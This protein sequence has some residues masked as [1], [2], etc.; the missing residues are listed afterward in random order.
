MILN[1]KTY[2]NL[3]DVVH[4]KKNIDASIIHFGLGA[5]FKAHFCSYIQAYNDLEKEIY[6]INA[7]SFKSNSTKIIMNQ[8]DNLYTVHERGPKNSSFQVI[9][10]IKN[11]LFLEEDRLYINDLLISKKTQIITLTIT[12]KGYY[13]SP[14]INGLDINNKDIIHDLKNKKE[15]KSAIGLICYALQTRRELK[16]DGLT[17]MSCDNL[18]SNGKILKKVI[19]DFAELID[20]DLKIWIE[21]KCTFP[22]TMVDRIVPKMTN[23]SYNYIE[24]IIKLKDKAGIVCED[25]S[26]FVI[27]DKFIK[28]KPALNEVGVLYVKDIDT[29]ENMK[30]RILNG[31]HSA[32]AYLGV[33]LKKKT[34]FDT[35]SEDYLELFIKNLLVKE[36]LPSLQ[37]VEGVNLNVYSQKILQRYRN[38]NIVHKTIQICMDGSLKLPQRWLS[39]LKYLLCTNKNYT[40]FALCLAAW[41]KCTSSKNLEGQSIE[42]NDPSALQYL[43]IWEEN[44]SALSIVY[45]YFSLSDIFEDFFKNEKILIEKVANYLDNIDNL[46]QLIK[47]INHENDL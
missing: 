15:A 21:N 34:I 31:T 28:K 36:I 23:E 5:F 35:I 44:E 30:L 7:I 26:Q 13:Y 40:G 24:E 3:T 8:Q 41:I 42:V 27:E 29:Y 19:L 37:S 4:H 47:E 25:F 39:T 11:A 1:N 32:Q 16:L 43:K 6:L 17:L 20:I 38:N 9:S 14:F 12:E 18:P 2:L 45:A 10:C 46:E 22:S 33:L